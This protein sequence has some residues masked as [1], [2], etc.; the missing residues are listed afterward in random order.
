MKKKMR[1]TYLDQWEWRESRTARRQDELHFGER[2]AAT[3]RWQGLFSNLAYALSPEGEWTFDRPRLLSR[4]VEVRDADSDALVAVL[5]VK[6]RGDATLEF[7]DGHT[8][9]W[10]P[11]NFWQTE[12]AFFETAEKD[13]RALISFVD[14]LR[15]LE[16]RTAVTFY[17]S[18]LPAQESALLT[19]LGH[20]LMVLHRN[21]TAAVTAATTAAVV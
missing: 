10:A 17:R 15:V 4:D 20:Y 16:N 5:Y 9:D 11:T 6:W 8:V 21:D 13:E 3:L 12:W 19:L 14:T 18:N 1:K 7:A 2:V